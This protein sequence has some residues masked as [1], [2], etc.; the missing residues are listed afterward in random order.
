MSNDAL[1]QRVAELLNG[2]C[3]VPQEAW[4]HIREL[5]QIRE[6]LL[7]LRC[8]YQRKLQE[9]RERLRIPAPEKGEA[10]LTDFDRQTMLA[11]A[12]AEDQE[13]YEYCVGL[14]KLIQE[15][16]ILLKELI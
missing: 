5:E 1:V 14:E 13:R 4:T 6:P 12:V 3:W 15:R 8:T 7:Q 9:E 10:R 16:V 11:A 2:D